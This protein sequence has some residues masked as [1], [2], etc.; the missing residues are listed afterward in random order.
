[1]LQTIQPG[2]V[3]GGPEGPRIR[4]GHLIHTMAYGGIETALLNW[5]RTMDRRRFEVTL[6]CFDNPGAT[7]APFVE[8]AARD[9]IAVELVGWSRRKPI[10]RAARELAAIARR[11]RLD[12]IHSHNTYANLVNLA[13]ARISRH[14]TVNTLYVWSN[15]LGFVRS[16][17][18]W[19]DRLTMPFFDQV[20]AHC[21]ETFEA[22]VKLG[23][24]PERLRL[25]V[26][27]FEAKVAHLSSEERARRRAELGAAPEDLVLI[28]V[29]RFWPEKAHDVLLNGF[30]RILARVPTAR[31]WITGVGP[32]EENIRKLCTTLGLDSR[33][34]FLGFR[35]DLAELLAQADIQVHPSDVEGVPLAICAGLAAGLP[36]VAT[37]VGGLPEV[38]RDGVSGVL[39]PPRNPEAFAAAVVRLAGDEMAR[40]RLG[41]AGQR[42]IDE[43]YSL[44]AAT[45]RVERLYEEIL[46]RTAA[47]TRRQQPAAGAEEVWTGV[48]R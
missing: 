31:L 27:G 3:S 16:A 33:V 18:Q 12:L 21:Q 10:L 34:S 23:M 37:K 17:L 28:N 48:R 2:G 7:Q 8:A 46:A 45:R 24:Q 20:T 9:G 38:I 47:G 14:R 35:T 25:L 42:F 44:K 29:A 1:M 4:V 39:I 26:C 5:I 11:Y 36:I 19:A 41:A 6:I 43:E 40:R 22:T 32:E 30:A 15:G 13:A